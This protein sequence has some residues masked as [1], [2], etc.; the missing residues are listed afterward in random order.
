MVSVIRNVSSSSNTSYK[1]KSIIAAIR[2]PRVARITLYATPSSPTEDYSDLDGAEANLPEVAALATGTFIGDAPIDV[3]FDGAFLTAA[4]YPRYAEV[5]TLLDE[6]EKSGKVY[7][8]TERVPFTANKSDCEAAAIMR[9]KAKLTLLT[10]QTRASYFSLL[11]NVTEKE[12][13]KQ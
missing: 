5:R 1:L 3:V 11:S 9:T 4:R 8:S 6:A 10:N 2:D 7:F 12:I 13:N